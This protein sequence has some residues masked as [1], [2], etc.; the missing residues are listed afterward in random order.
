MGQT[1]SIL[2]TSTPFVAAL[3]TPSTRIYFVRH[4]LALHN[5]LEAG[6]CNDTF[7]LDPVLVAQGHR[8]ALDAGHL[9]ARF[10]ISVDI[11]FVSPLFRALQTAA[12]LRR[13]G[14]GDASVPF[15][16]VAQL[17]PPVQVVESLREHGSACTADWRRPAS[18]SARLFPSFD[19]SNLLPGFDVDPFR[20][21]ET[22]LQAAERAT[23]F[24]GTLRTNAASAIV[25]AGRAVPDS[26]Q[27]SIIVVSHAS[28]LDDLLQSDAGLYGLAPVATPLGPAY[29]YEARAI[30]N[31]EV[32]AFDV[33][34]PA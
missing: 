8:E 21:L 14:W 16:A 24:L 29:S 26:V 17:Q 20:S 19:F 30:R 25:A 32:L 3:V 28:F 4:G 12:L 11:I 6:H 2:L 15:R 27:T 33:R 18:E 31:G 23:S 10:D 22:P 34:E 7:V 1:I 9:F 13:A 5:V